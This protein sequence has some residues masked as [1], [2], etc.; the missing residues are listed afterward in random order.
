[1]K[2]ERKRV[3]LINRYALFLTLVLEVF[4]VYTAIAPNKG[5]NPSTAFR[6]CLAALVIGCQIVNFIVYAK[7][8]ASAF[9]LR[10]SMWGFALTYFITLTGSCSD[11]IYLAIFPMA[12]VHILH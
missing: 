8:K 10:F 7:D 6:I 2:P 3:A 12:S 4:F 5:N 9:F 11:G 1:M